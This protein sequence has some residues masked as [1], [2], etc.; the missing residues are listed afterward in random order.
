MGISPGAAL[1][2]ASD[3][4]CR[5]GDAAGTHISVVILISVC[6]WKYGA[7]SWS[8]GTRVVALYAVLLLR[9]DVMPIANDE[10]SLMLQIPAP[11]PWA[12]CCSAS[13]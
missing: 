13:S 6:R 11:S 3:G 8:P 12:R 10:L 4:G 2:V 1:S 9:P 7:G 5:N